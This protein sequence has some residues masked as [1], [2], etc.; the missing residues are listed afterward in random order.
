MHHHHHLF[1]CVCLLF[2]VPSLRRDVFA[3]CAAWTFIT[4]TPVAMWWKNPTIVTTKRKRTCW[5]RSNLS[6]KNIATESCTF[7]TIQWNEKSAN[8]N[9]RHTATRTEN[10]GQ[11]EE[12]EDK[13][14]R[15]RVRGIPCHFSLFLLLLL[16]SSLL[17]YFLLSSYLHC[18][19][20]VCLLACLLAC[21]CSLWWFCS[22]VFT[23]F[24]LRSFR[25]Y[26]RS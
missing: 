25:R 5:K 6:R 20:F 2:S 16:P 11:E 7:P 21:L 8:G 9:K 4:R 24:P 22:L 18:L 13:L 19:F 12:E 14:R 26:F 3:S 17:F 10:A 1:L 23:F 15:E